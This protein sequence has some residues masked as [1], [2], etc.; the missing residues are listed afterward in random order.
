MEIG[1]AALRNFRQFNVLERI[2]QFV[3]NGGIS[4]RMKTAAGADRTSTSVSELEFRTK[5]GKEMFHGMFHGASRERFTKCSTD[6]SLEMEQRSA[7]AKSDIAFHARH[8][9]ERES[10]GHKLSSGKANRERILFKKRILSG[11]TLS[12]PLWRALE[13]NLDGLFRVGDVEPAAV[14]LPTFGEHLD[15]HAT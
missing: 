2:A 15:Q 1:A 9:V 3:C 7:S 6:V 8:I 5:R 11:N 14:T 10:R 12:V 4:H 13:A